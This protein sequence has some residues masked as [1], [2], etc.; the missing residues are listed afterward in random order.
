MIPKYPQVFVEDMAGENAFTILGAVHKA[1]RKASIP[2][3]EIEKFTAEAT[4]SDYDAL[5]LTVEKWVEVI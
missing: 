3:D 4:S 5:L 2:K 1:M